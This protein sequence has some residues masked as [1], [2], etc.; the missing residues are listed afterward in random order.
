MKQTLVII[1]LLALVTLSTGCAASGNTVQERRNSVKEMEEETLE[2]FYREVTFAKRR[3]ENA[4][5]YGVFSNGNVNLIIASA[6][7]GYGVVVDHKTGERNPSDTVC[8]D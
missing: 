1:A 4:A 6:G 7:T 3:L 8:R 5:G 2:R